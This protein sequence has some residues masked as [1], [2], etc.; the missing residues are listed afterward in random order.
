[1]TK[2]HRAALL[3]SMVLQACGDT[4][5]AE[6]A[7][8]EQSAT[9]LETAAEPQDILARLQSIPGLSVVLE[10]PSPFPG[11][12]FFLLQFEQPADHE[13]PQGSASSSG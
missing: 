5:L 7:P 4:S 13:R 8:A 6:S 11:T 10:Q 1:M 3:L 2:T 12:R 9:A